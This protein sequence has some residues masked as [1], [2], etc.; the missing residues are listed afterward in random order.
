VWA[1]AARAARSYKNFADVGVFFIG[2][3]GLPPQV[4]ATSPDGKLGA[5]LSKSAGTLKLR[6]DN[7]DVIATQRIEL[8]RAG[9]V[10]GNIQTPSL[11]IEQGG[12]FEGSCKMIQQKAA[13]EKAAHVDR[14]DNVIEAT[15]LEIKTDTAKKNEDGKVAAIAVAS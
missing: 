6:T 10:N 3:S 5:E 8:G 14:K 4:G 13:S 1:V 9:K 7:G 12:V 11:V 2:G 15:K